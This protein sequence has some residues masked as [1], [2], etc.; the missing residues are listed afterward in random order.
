MRGRRAADG[1]LVAS[2]QA[3][4]GRPPED[5]RNQSFVL[6]VYPALSLRLARR[7]LMIRTFS[8]SPDSLCVYAT[9]STRDA[10]DRPSRRKRASLAECAKS[11]P[12][13]ASGSAKTV[14]ASSN[15]TSCFARLAAAFFASHSNTYFSIYTIGVPS[16]P[17]R[18][19]FTSPSLPVH[20]VRYCAHLERLSIAW[21]RTN[22][23]LLHGTLDML[24]LNASRG[25]AARLRHRHSPR[26]A[27]DGGAQG[28]RRIALPRAL[29]DGKRR[30]IGR[31]GPDREQPAGAG[32]QAHPRGRAQ[33][34]AETESSVRLTAAVRASSAVAHAGPLL[35]ARS[36]ALV[37]RD[38]VSDESARRFS[39]TSRR[40]AIRAPWAPPR[41]RAPG[42]AHGLGASRSS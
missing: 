21:P 8:T 14:T 24:V 42:G 29:P 13:S 1:R 39:S 11:G 33:F 37:G 20:V 10:T 9:M 22:S 28:G 2:P 6:L 41:G 38:A 3:D 27:V 30:W 23:D 4:P 5:P 34:E 12:S 35:P 19:S 31:S 32:L 15:A 18:L 40:P 26:P 36:R 7:A 16:G 17:A 25:S